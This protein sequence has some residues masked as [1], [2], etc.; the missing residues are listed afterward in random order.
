MEENYL[1]EKFFLKKINDCIEHN[2]EEKVKF[3]F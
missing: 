2:E 3:H 1:D